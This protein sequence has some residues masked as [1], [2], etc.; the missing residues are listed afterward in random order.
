MTTSTP[1][2]GP[3]YPF[4]SF[5]AAFNDGD[6]DALDRVYEPEGVLVPRSGYPVTGSARSAANAYLLGFGLPM[7]AHLRHVYVAGD[8]AL[9]I[10]DW[11]LHGT[12]RDGSAVDL[13]GTA[14]DVTRCGR[15]GVWRY[16]IDNPSGTA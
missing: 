6:S 7:R 9:L 3:A 2:D 11:S 5:L 14:S 10:V 16:V 15:D 12:A 4:A 8:I 13:R 1:H